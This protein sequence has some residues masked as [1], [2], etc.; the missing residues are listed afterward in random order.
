MIE[1]TKVIVAGGKNQ[2]LDLKELGF[3]IHK[4]LLQINKEKTN[5]TKEKWVKEMNRQ[6]TEKER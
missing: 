2:H 6:F 3:I 4:E 1:P 5:N